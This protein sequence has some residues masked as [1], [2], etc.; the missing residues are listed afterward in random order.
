MNSHTL[1]LRPGDDPKAVL[2]ALAKEKGWS[3]ACVICA[4]G[5]LTH[6]ALRFADQSEVA[7]LRG[8]FEIVSLTG[9]LSPDGSHLHLAISDEKG[10]T[11]GGHLKEGSRVYTTV[12]IV[13]AILE[14]W[15]FSRQIDEE[16]GF[17]EL[18]VEPQ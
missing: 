14:D 18:F 10:L 3:A 8:H 13:L 5:S 12:E 6:A 16:T 1:R 15:K 17:K 11:L 7:L 2:D 4:V 9:T